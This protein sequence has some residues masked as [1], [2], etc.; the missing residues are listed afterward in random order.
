MDLRE[1]HIAIELHDAEGIKRFLSS[2]DSIQQGW[3]EKPW[4]ELLIG[5]YTR[6]PKF[7]ACVQA[8]LES[9]DQLRD[10]ILEAVLTNDATRLSQE[11][12]KKPAEVHL[13]YTFSSAYTP[14]FEVSLLHLC[15]EFNHVAC[16]EVL[17]QQGLSIDTPAGLDSLGFG[18]QTPI[19]HTVNQ[20]SNQ[21]KEML[22][23]CLRNQGSLDIQLKG[24]IWGK[25]RPWETFLPDVSPISYAT[26]GLLPQMHRNEKTVAETVELLMKHKYGMEYKLPN[27]PNTYLLS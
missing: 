22:D 10:D 26:M 12:Q 5:E 23:F 13:I 7:K 4:V 20:N 15:A 1:L 16:A 9:G 6:G 27:I 24:L 17:I 3:D 18:G 21:S 19:F 11:I 25:D 14:F 8:F 2:V